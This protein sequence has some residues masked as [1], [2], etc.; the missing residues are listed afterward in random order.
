MT[1]DYFSSEAAKDR[2]RTLNQ[3]GSPEKSKGKHPGP[4]SVSIDYAITR[5]FELLEGAVVHVALLSVRDDVSVYLPLFDRASE[6]V[7]YLGSAVL[8]G[9]SERRVMDK[10]K[11]LYSVIADIGARASYDK[12]NPGWVEVGESLFRKG[13][14][15]AR[16]CNFSSSS[17]SLPDK[18]QLNTIFNGVN[19]INADS[20]IDG[21]ISERV[22]GIPEW[23]SPRRAIVFLDNYKNQRQVPNV[24]GGN[25]TI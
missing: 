17:V 3:S 20:L 14:H 19:S 5:A 4:V 25:G 6:L 7:R 18:A 24:G 12:T 1:P 23:P 9:F 8:N 22:I 21:L 16:H 13:E 15:F 10:T 2:H 11:R